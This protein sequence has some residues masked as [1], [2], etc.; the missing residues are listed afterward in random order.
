MNAL[1]KG[2]VYAYFTT[3]KLGLTL[4]EYIKI[5]N[6]IVIYT[7]HTVI[8][9]PWFSGRLVTARSQDLTLTTSLNITHIVFTKSSMCETD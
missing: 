5:N 4:H 3:S 8:H 2:L 6:I 1:L 9:N 7:N